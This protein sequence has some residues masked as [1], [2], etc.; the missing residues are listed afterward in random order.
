MPPLGSEAQH[1]AV[2]GNWFT[3]EPAVDR[4]T[5]RLQAR[6]EEGIGRATEAEPSL[7]GKLY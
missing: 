1:E 2:G 3:D 7:T 5:R 6:P 4:G